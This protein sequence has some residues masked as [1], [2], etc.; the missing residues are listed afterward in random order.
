MAVAHL[1]KVFDDDTTINLA[2]VHITPRGV[3]VTLYVLA[4]GAVTAGTVVLE[5]SG[6]GGATWEILLTRALTATGMFSDSLINTHAL[7]R[8]RITVA[9]VGGTGVDAWIQ[10]SGPGFGGV[11]A[12]RDRSAEAAV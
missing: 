2:S 12:E 4:N 7:V 11:D 6:D 8:A 3:Y 10:T 9:I 5:V 1:T